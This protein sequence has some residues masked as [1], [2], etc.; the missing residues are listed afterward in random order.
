MLVSV[1]VKAVTGFSS[2]QE[3]KC[4]KRIFTLSVS[5]ELILWSIPFFPTEFHSRY[6]S[7][8]WIKEIIKMISNCFKKC[9]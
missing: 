7:S 5:K 8:E 3:E 1:M 4:N 6:I 2:Q 9:V